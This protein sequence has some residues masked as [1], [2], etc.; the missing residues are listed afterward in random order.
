MFCILSYLL[1][2]SGF[3]LKSLLESV[4]DRYRVS[5]NLALK[6]D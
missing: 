3:S 4:S 1:P 5:L 6:S 2:V